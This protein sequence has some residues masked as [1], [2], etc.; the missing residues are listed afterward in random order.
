[1]RACNSEPHRA[2]FAQSR[3]RAPS[4]PCGAS[5]GAT[6]PS[7][8]RATGG[9]AVRRRP[10]GRYPEQEGDPPCAAQRADGSPSAPTARRSWRGRARAW[11]MPVPA[12][13][14]G[15]R[16]RSR[17]PVRPWQ[18]SP[19]RAGSIV[20]GDS[21]PSKPF[22]AASPQ[23][24]RRAMIWRRQTARIAAE[25]GQPC[26]VGCCG[27]WILPGVASSMMGARADGVN[28]QAEAAPRLCRDYAAA[29]RTLTGTAGIKAR[30]CAELCVAR[31]CTSVAQRDTTRSMGEACAYAR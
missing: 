15:R 13:N 8:R 16:S 20:R 9:P 4:L 27:Q 24:G 17:P 11:P 2:P 14:R 1:M 3:R 12:M 31:G 10:V 25:S 23:A 21:A 18:D 19:C 30:A 6:S 7:A 28:A 26:H 29:S 5:P 22:G